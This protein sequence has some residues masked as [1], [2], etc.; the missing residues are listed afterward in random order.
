[1]FALAAAVCWALYIVFGQKMGNAHSGQTAALGTVVGA[2]FIVPIGVGYAGWTLLSPGILPAACAVALLSSA[3]PYTLEMYA[4]SRVPA[5]T[6]GVLMSLDPAL[7]ALSGLCF[8]GET[9]SIVQWG[10]IA[11]IICASAGSAATSRSA[12]PQALPD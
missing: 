8:L 10:A 3:L 2:I 11:S 9:L 5:R 1:L 4:L 7:A 6:F 12:P